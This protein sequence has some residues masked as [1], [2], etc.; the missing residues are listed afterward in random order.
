MSINLRPITK[1]NWREITRLTPKRG[2]NNWVAPNWYSILEKILDE[3][4]MYSMGIYEGD[5]PVGYTLYGYYEEDN[6]YYILRLMIDKKLQKRGYGR[7]AMRAIIDAMWQIPEC[8][9]IYISF[10]ADNDI[11]RD[12]YISLGF[13]DTGEVIEGEIIYRLDATN[14]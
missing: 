11:A 14:R 1:D 4:P 6:R 5:K 13:V 12:L 10:V 8:D 9:V 3:S 7:S 2:Q